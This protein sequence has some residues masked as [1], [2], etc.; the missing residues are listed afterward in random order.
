MII[1]GCI[2]SEEEILNLVDD[3]ER[4]KFLLEKD[5]D[6]RAWDVIDEL[7][8]KHTTFSFINY[9]GAGKTAYIF[10]KQYFNMGGGETKQDYEQSVVDKSK[11]IFNLDLHHTMYAIEGD[12]DD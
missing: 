6:I 10:G 12:S 1:F 4:A 5:Y 11:E 9:F 7:K 2:L 3:V 8:K